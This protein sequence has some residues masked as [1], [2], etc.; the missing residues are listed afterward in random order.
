MLEG[1]HARDG[2]QHQREGGR[3]DADASQHAGAQH[4]HRRGRPEGGDAHADRIAQ[5][6]DEEDAERAEAVR[7]LAGD[8]RGQSEDQI[9]DGER[10]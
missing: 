8:G 7:Q 5:A 1:N 6:T 9:L 2:S 10:E 3:A 4:P